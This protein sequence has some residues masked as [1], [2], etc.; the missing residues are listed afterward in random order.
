MELNNIGELS[1]DTSNDVAVVTDTRTNTVIDRIG[2][3]KDLV[4]SR[5][6]TGKVETNIISPITN[7]DLVVDLQPDN[8]TEA[9]KLVIK[10][11]DDS[12]VASIDATGKVTADSLEIVNDATVAGTL[13]ADKIE[14]SK[15]TEIEDLL[16]EVESNQDILA[17]SASWEVNTATDSGEIIANTIQANSLFVTGQAAM[18]SLFVSDN[19]AT[20]S[21]NSLDSVLGIQSLA[22]MPVEIM[23]GKIKIDTNGNI[24]FSGNVEVAGDLTVN[25][26][27]V[28][29]SESIAT[30][31]AQINSGE[32]TTNSI[33]GKAVLPAGQTDIKII[34]PKLKTEGL[35]YVTPVSSTQNKVLYVK[36]KDIGTFTV[37]F[38]EAIDTDVEFNWWIIDLKS[39]NI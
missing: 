10:G 16:K 2:A 19:L 30:E 39:D 22:A 18:T 28:A 36:S 13:Y 5:I 25:N 21:V 24:F 3:F 12:E 32:I 27:V 1:I 23:A 34:N 31:S 8:N 33:A 14:S 9:S 29:N 4:A 6:K 11:E 26:L 17:Q 38:S 20:K 7:S 35:I 37:G 15:L